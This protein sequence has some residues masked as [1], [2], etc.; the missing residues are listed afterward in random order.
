MKDGKRAFGYFDDFSL[1]KL[2]KFQVFLEAIFDWEFHLSYG[3][4]F[5]FLT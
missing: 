3:R 1:T 5:I 2:C 4:L